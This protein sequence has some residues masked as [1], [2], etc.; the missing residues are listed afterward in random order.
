[1]ELRDATFN[2]FP[3]LLEIMRQVHE[4]SVF[5]GMAMNDATIQRNF[6]V[7]MSFDD[8][9][10]KVAE[11]NGEIVGGLVGMIADNQFGIRCAQDLFNH[12]LVGTDRLIKDF[13]HWASVRDTRFVLITDLTG[14]PRYVKLCQALGFEAIGTNLMKVM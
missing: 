12:S 13:L 3:E 1:M 14:N 10:A 7:A 8:G 9:Y 2:D 11:R 5:K 4:D 6:V